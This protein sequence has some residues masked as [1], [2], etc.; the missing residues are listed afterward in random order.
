MEHQGVRDT[1]RFGTR[2]RRFGTGGTVAAVAAVAA[3]CAVAVL[4]TG[5]SWALRQPEPRPTVEVVAPGA[6]EA[7]VLPA[8]VGASTLPVVVAA[9][10]DSDLEVIRLDP[11]PAPP[12]ETTTIHAFVANRGPDT[13]ASPFTVVVTLPKGVTP[14]GPY[15]PE[16]CEVAEHGRQVRC[17]FGPGLKEGRSAT[18]LVPVLLS[19]DLP[20][21]TLVGGSVAVRSADDRDGDNNRQPFDIRVVETA[22][23]S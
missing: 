21:G 9:P 6:P 3:G 13:T 23:G 1:V 16:D 11:D 12:G 10:S 19:P 18:A 8:V 15:F 20:L 14:E 5:P 17:V 4:A 2:H 22:A 7:S